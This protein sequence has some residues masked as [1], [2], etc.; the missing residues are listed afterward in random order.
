MYILLSALMAPEQVQILFCRHTNEHKASWDIER[1][2]SLKYV[3]VLDAIRQL[4]RPQV[5]IQ[6]DIH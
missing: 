3:A 5:L 2:K 4:G 6:L 1:A